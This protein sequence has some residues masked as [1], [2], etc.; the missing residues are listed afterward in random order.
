MRHELD[1]REYKL[2]LNPDR[3]RGASPD[4]IVGIFWE[5]QF[6]PL[7]DARLGSRSGRR[8]TPRGAITEKRERVIRF[9]DTRDCM[10]TRADLTLRARL[11]VGDEGRADAQPEITLRLRKADLFVVAAADLP[12]AVRAHAQPSRRILRRLR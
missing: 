9:W 3:F 6:M 12:A 2:L 5:E 7:I 1:A 4:K 10:L 8:T 11:F